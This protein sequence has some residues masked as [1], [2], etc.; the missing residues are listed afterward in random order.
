MSES[1]YK[2]DNGLAGSVLQ[3]AADC[4]DS[5]NFAIEAKPAPETCNEILSYECDAEI[6]DAEKNGKEQ[7][8][9]CLEN[10]E[11]VQVTKYLS[12]HGRE[13]ASDMKNDYSCYVKDFLNDEGTYRFKGRGDSIEKAI[14]LAKTACL[15]GAVQ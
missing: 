5:Q 9:V 11:C 1:G 14:E 3:S 10:N 4:D 6:V 13:I 12:D 7:D 2:L 15:K 8:S